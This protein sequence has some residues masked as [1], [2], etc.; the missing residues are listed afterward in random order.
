MIAMYGMPVENLEME[1]KRLC[2]IC[3]AK[4]DIIC[5]EYSFEPLDMAQLTAPP[6]EFAQII[7]AY[8]YDLGSAEY[9]GFSV[10]LIAAYDFSLLTKHLY[11]ADISPENIPIMRAYV[12]NTMPCLTYSKKMLERITLGAILCFNEYAHAKRYDFALALRM[13]R[14]LQ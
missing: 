4:H 2:A 6:D 13:Y 11:S 14:L 9:A 5:R 8:S 12:L 3:H 1:K 10:G 7:E